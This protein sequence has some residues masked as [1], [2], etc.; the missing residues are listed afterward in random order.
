MISGLD[1]GAYRIE[2][3]IV[4]LGGSMNAI[5]TIFYYVLTVMRKQM[6]VLAGCAVG[7]VFA[8]VV[9]FLFVRAYGLTGAVVS[10]VITMMTTVV[11]FGIFIM[12]NMK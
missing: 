2:V 4:M 12:Y 7:F 3:V 1:L 11:V 8:L 5:I 9:P 10:Y 6:L